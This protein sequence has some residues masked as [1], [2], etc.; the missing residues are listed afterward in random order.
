MGTL[1][2]FRLL[3]PLIILVVIVLAFWYLLNTLNTGN[4]LWFVPF[5]PEYTPS[6][7][8]VHDYG[9]SVELRPGD[10]GFDQLAAALNETLSAF[11]NRDLVPIGIGDETLRAYYEE[12]LVVEAFYATEV[13]FN[14]PARFEGINTLLIPVD[15]RHA[16]NNYVFLGRNRE[17]LA[18]ALQ[19]ESREPLDNAL[20]VLGYL[21]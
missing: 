12:G 7:I 15:A 20:R 8:V 16:E 19:V 3:E 6:R 21:E 17:F 14:L 4:P 5:Q 1:R 18:S 2:R 9:Q 10:A 13:R 11:K